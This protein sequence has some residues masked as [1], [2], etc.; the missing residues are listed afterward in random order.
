M[1]QYCCCRPSPTSLVRWRFRSAAIRSL[2]TRVLST[3]KR[4]TTCSIS[5]LLQLGGSVGI[6]EPPEPTVMR[7][8]DLCRV[9]VRADG[10]L[11]HAVE[12]RRLVA[13]AHEEEDLRGGVQH[14][15]G[16][17]DAPHSDFSDEF[18]HDPALRLVHRPQ[19]REEG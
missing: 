9:R 15:R 1:S 7:R 8:Y 4:K 2:S 5:A 16:E 13:A 10:T 6:D 14:D 18:R 11:E 19:P 3:S 12:H 17:R